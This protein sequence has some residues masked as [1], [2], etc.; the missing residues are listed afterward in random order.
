MSAYVIVDIHVN[1]PEGYEEVR[2][3]TPATVAAFG[4]R[5]LA[6]GGRT[7][8]LEGDWRPERLVILEFESIERA[9]EWLESPEYQPIKAA[10]HRCAR[11]RMV[12]IEG[13]PPGYLP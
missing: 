12:V 5:Y 2:R 6:R 13:L 8:S 10:R 11:T 4:G 7:E 9:R 1:D 3:L